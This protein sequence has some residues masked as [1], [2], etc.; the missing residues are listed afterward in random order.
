MIGWIKRIGLIGLI[1]IILTLNVAWAADPK[2]Q[3]VL[4][5]LPQ[6]REIQ[7]TYEKVRD[8]SADF[9]HTVQFG[10]FE[11]RSVSSGK[12]FFKRGA[13]DAQTGAGKMRWDYEAPQRSQIFIDGE[14]V[15]HYTPEHRQVMKSRLQAASSLPLR[16]LSGSGRID[17]DFQ[18]VMGDA[19]NTWLLTPREKIAGIA[20]IKARTSPFPP[21]G[22][23]ILTEV[24]LHEDNGNIVTFSF[25]KI[26]V[27]QGLKDDHFRFTPPKGVEVIE[28][29]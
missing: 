12:F 18:V 26:R 11:S 10:D 9:V 17:R 14:S 2:P 29:P 8:L 7:A 21:L 22:G 5:L 25:E 27:N 3:A 6:I 24:T 19:P 23:P 16:L 4:P 1:G 28:S 15:L 13:G 20:R